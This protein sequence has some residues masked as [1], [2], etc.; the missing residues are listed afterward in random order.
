MTGL[1]ISWPQ[2]VS[3]PKIQNRLSQILNKARVQLGSHSQDGINIIGLYVDDG[4][5][6]ADIVETTLQKEPGL[7]NS[8]DYLSITAVK[9]VRQMVGHQQSLFVNEK[10]VH[11]KSGEIRRLEL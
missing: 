7:F 1:M 11:V 5:I 10:N 2:V 4:S 9:Y 3:I 8:G 6:K